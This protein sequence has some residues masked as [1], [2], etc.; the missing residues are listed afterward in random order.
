MR[1]SRTF[2]ARRLSFLAL[3]PLVLLTG[4]KRDEAVNSNSSTPPGQ[5]TTEP[6]HASR[7][8][9]GAARTGGGA[10]TADVLDSQ[11]GALHVFKDF[12]VL[13]W[14]QRHIVILREGFETTLLESGTGS[15]E[16]VAA[17]T[18]GMLYYSVLG[19]DPHDEAKRAASG[20]DVA[21]MATVTRFARLSELVAT[22]SIE[23]PTGWDKAPVVVVAWESSTIQD[24]TMDGNPDPLALLM[25]I[26]RRSAIAISKS[27]G[28]TIGGMDG[29]GATVI[30]NLKEYGYTS[31][32]FLFAGD[33]SLLEKTLEFTSDC[34]S[35]DLIRSDGSQVRVSME[36]AQPEAAIAFL[37]KTFTPAEQAAIQYEITFTKLSIF[38]QKRATLLRQ[39][40]YRDEQIQ[41]KSHDAW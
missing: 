11:S 37:L 2:A 21:H 7:P 31:E 18:A 3:V 32:S 8:P 20:R 36:P 5:S 28:R 27:S 16:N 10:K 34:V 39:A 4:C 41:L 25:D 22:T 26:N 6:P 23:V 33:V 24:K 17:T 35:R 40:G 1:I 12:L 19:S 30:Q 13:E 29:L 38:D 14:R 9:Q 15:F